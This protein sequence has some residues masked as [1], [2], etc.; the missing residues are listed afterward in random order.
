MPSSHIKKA[1][2]W[3]MIDKSPFVKGKTL[4]FKENNKRLRFLTDEETPK[5]LAE[6]PT[7]LRPIVECALH[8]GMRRGEILNLKWSQIKN[9]FIYLHETKTNE[10]R[11]IPVNDALSRLFKEIRRK[12]GLKHEHV[13]IR[14]LDEQTKKRGNLR[15]AQQPIGGFRTDFENAVRRAD[16]KDFHFHDLRHTFDSHMIMKGASLK[17]VQ[18]ILGHKTMEMTMR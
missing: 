16:I 9:G 17:E 7:Y 3:E 14:V 12:Q 18:E 15:L 2:E 11:E 8:T 6:C 1:V 5:L 4:I 13:F 10:S